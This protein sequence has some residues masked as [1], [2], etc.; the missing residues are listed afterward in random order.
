MSVIEKMNIE[1]ILNEIKHVIDN[2]LQNLLSEF[3]EKYNK[4]EENYHAVLDLP[5]VRNKI[6][7]L[8]SNMGNNNMGNGNTSNG[9]TN[10]INTMYKTFNNQMRELQRENEELKLEITNLKNKLPRVVDLTND[11]DFDSKIVEI[12]IE[13]NLNKTLV[14]ESEKENITLIIE[15]PVS[16]D[17]EEESVASLDEEDDASLV[18]SLEEESLE[19]L[20]DESVASLEDKSKEVVIESLEDK[21]KEVVIESLEEVVADE[22]DDAD[23]EEEEEDA[24]LEEEEE[25]EEEE[26]VAD[27]EESDDKS[28]ETETKEEEV[29]ASLEEEEEEEVVASL[30]EEEEELF[31]IEIDDKTYC[32]NNEETGFIYELDSEGNVGDKIGYFKEGEPIFYSEE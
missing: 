26:S 5:A 9:N 4:Y 10:I 31:E 20:E 2:G 27:E 25:E 14:K 11:S 18:A 3:M 15:E 24:S 7:S 32:T 29:V 13:K 23:E 19:S 17:V 28:V 1:P 22:E 6:T 30:E 21:S 8:S 12:K 16:N